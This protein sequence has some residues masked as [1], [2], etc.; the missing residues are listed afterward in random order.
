MSSTADKAPAANGAALG[1][2]NAYRTVTISMGALPTAD[3]TLIFSG[4]Y[5][6]PLVVRLNDRCC[7]VYCGNVEEGDAEIV[8]LG[9]SAKFVSTLVAAHRDGYTWV[10]F[11]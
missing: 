10:N 9:F 7:W 11:L 1:G 5:R 8:R 4:D 2:R 6:K 3:R